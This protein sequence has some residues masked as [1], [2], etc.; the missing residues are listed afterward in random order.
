M[1]G[2]A[3][4]VAGVPWH[5]RFAGGAA[6]MVAKAEV[7]NVSQAWGEK[8]SNACARRDH[9]VRGSGALAL[10]WGEANGSQSPTSGSCL[11]RV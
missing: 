6:V 11:E 5:W 7:V 8:A 3:G 10:L 1:T 9:R 2:D 4:R